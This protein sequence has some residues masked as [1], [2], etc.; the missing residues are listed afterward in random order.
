MNAKLLIELRDHL[1]TETNPETF[2]MARWY[3]PET[4][5]G[6]AAY[7]LSKISDLNFVDRV[8][9]Y[10]GTVPCPEYMGDTS[11]TALSKLLDMNMGYIIYIIYIFYAHSPTDGTI[12]RNPTP[13]DIADRIDTVLSAIQEQAESTVSSS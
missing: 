10:G 8:I 13:E 9:E 5:C 11:F 6:C 12:S 4:D 7:E 2:D 3:N 1:R